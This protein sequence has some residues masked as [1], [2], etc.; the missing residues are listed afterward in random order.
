MIFL[1]V[2]SDKKKKVNLLICC[3]SFRA[4]LFYMLACQELV[5]YVLSCHV[6]KQEF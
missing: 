5:V 2:M 6:I 4:P 3:Q 1:I